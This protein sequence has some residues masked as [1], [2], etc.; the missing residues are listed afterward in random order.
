MP[1]SAEVAPEMQLIRTA[2]ALGLYV[3]KK[4][5]ELRGMME[6][7]TASFLDTPPLCDFVDR[8]GGWVSVV[9]PERHMDGLS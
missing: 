8:Q 1:V 5:P 7:A 6:Q 4:A 3:M 9:A 2:V